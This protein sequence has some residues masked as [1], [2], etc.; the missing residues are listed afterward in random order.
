MGVKVKEEFNYIPEIAKAIEYLGSH[1]LEIGI[2]GEDDSHIL[3]IARVH[4]F[5][6]EIEVTEKMRNYL[7]A[8]GFHLRNDTDK[9]TIPERSFMRAGFDT[10]K[11][12]FQKTGEEIVYKVIGLKITP[13]AGLDILGNYIVT[14]LQEYLTKIS[15]PP[16]HP[17]TAQQKGSSNPLIDEGRLKQAITYKIRG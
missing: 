7:H 2:F 15:R 9:I 12:D 3:M 11:K 6:V 14:Q 8:I 10:K 17:F 16:N 1:H 13:K 4:E 5:G